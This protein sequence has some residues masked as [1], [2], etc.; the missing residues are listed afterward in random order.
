LKKLGAGSTTDI[1]SIYTETHVT[2]ARD[3]KTLYFVSDRPGGLGGRDIYRC[4][5]LPNGQ[6]SQALNVGAPINT[7]YDEATPFLHNNGKELFFSSNNNKSMGG[8]DI[9]Y[10]KL[11]ENNKWTE[12]L[13]LGYPVNTADDDVS[14]STTPDGKRGY[15]SS[16]KPGGNGEKDIYM[17]D[18]DTIS[19]E[20]VAILKGYIDLGGQ[21]ELPA[22]IVIWV[23][24]LT[25]GG[26]PL[27]YR[28][29]RRTGSYVFNLTPCHDYEVEYTK[30]EEV[31]YTTEFKVPCNSDYHVIN[32][33]ISLGGTALDGSDVVD[34]NDGNDGTDGTDGTDASKE[35]WTY[36]VFIGDKP[37]TLGGLASLMGLEDEEITQ[38]LGK[39]GKFKYRELKSKKDPIFVIEVTDPTLCDQLNIKLLD[40]NGK[41]VKVTSRDIR[42]KLKSV[43]VDPVEFQKFYGY[44]EKGV[45]S[46]GKRFK[47]LVDGIEKI[48]AA[49]GYASVELEGSAS[50]VP[51]RTFKNNK[52]LAGKR[53][54]E[55]KSILIKVLKKNGV[56]TSK[57]KVV[58]VNAVVQGPKYSGDYKNTEKY[59]KYQYIK[60]KAF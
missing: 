49:K 13:N 50:R 26:D 7:E 57:V 32:K 20:P 29:N 1:N 27:K 25:D 51:T 30:G 55:A 44:N 37:Y 22:A 38:L 45:A 59:G 23:T 15:Y 47:T 33:V 3:G 8:Y 56:D 31:F 6:W 28:P 9:F 19:S 41:V 14:F 21:S 58:A 42:C 54:G 60:I 4:V 35:D 5:K 12:P 43:A 11:D 24:D 40:E 48:I 17:I 18:M 53:S 52:D 2:M 46:E 34:G 16:A 39:D 10:T 36:Q